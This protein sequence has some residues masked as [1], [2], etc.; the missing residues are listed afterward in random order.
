MNK[1]IPFKYEELQKMMHNSG[2]DIVVANS[3]HNVR[4][5]L[6]GYFYH[7]H[8]NST[9]MGQSQYLPFVGLPAAQADSSFYV[10]RPDEADQMETQRPWIPNLVQA[11][12]GTRSSAAALA[13]H[14]KDS[15]LE[16]ARIGLE[17]PFFP[18]DAYLLLRQ[19]L[20]K[21][22]FADA[23]PIFEQLRARKTSLEIALLRTA[24]ANLAKSIH[25]T[26]LGSTEGETTMN[27][28]KR[29]QRQITTSGLSFLF[30]LVSAG[31]GFMRAP[32]SS[33]WERGQILHI[34]AGGSLQ[35]YVADICRMGC[36]G[37]PSPLARS[38]HRACIQVQDEV[39]AKI[40]P[41]FPC[42]ELLKIGQEASLSFPF[43]RYARFVVHG[44]GMVPYESP[45]FSPDSE[46]LLVEGM[47]LSIETDF[48]H[49]EIGHIKI[50][51]A[52]AITANG[53]EG[54]GD[55]GRDWTII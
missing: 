35:D 4:Y 5:V 45:M 48:L 50:E 7:F 2:L 40:K 43:S 19:A 10:H 25:T 6:G 8:E 39:R 3:R 15:G 33:R 52:V 44:I 22:E 42:K 14:L 34:D 1:K 9:R 55:T 36:I 11:L 38:I 41:G 21:A 32:S 26:F 13:K 12:R 17:M 54:L 24:Y 23:T 49:P 47:V 37:E 46:E 53:H 16:K 28:A 51:D 29:V 20:P 31:P 18:A 27:I 30:A